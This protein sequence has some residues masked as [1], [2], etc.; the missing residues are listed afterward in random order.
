MRIAHVITGLEMGGAEQMLYK[1]LATLDRAAFEPLVISLIEP[2]PMRAPIAALGVRIETLGMRRGLPSPGALLRLVGLLRAFRPDLIQTW[3]YHADLLGAL[4]RP[5]VGTR[6]GLIWNIRQSDLDPRHTRLGPRLVARLNG[7][8][9]YLAPD[10][11]ICCSQRAAAVHRALGY[12]ARLFEVI[13]NGFDLE[14]FHPDDAARAQLRAELGVPAAA[15]LLGLAGRF[16]PQKDLP[17][18][19]QAAALVRAARPESR[20]LLSGPGMERAN[21][22]LAGWMADAGLAGAIDLLGPRT[23]MPRVFAALDL[24][25]LSSAYGEGFPNVVGEAMACGVPCA[26]TDVGDSGLIVG[27][28]GAIVAPRDPTALAA[29]ILRLL[30]EDPPGRARRGVAARERIAAHYS[31]ARIVARYADLYQSMQRGTH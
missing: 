21:P 7:L 28:T 20:F 16:D 14:R 24:L 4:A 10:R 5:L 13:P 30:A 19:L 11:I 15:P 31:L 2:G 12:R 6:P 26:V 25:V 29:A 8:V 3:M 1:L 18:F 27:E 17:T 22:Q 23:D 9:S